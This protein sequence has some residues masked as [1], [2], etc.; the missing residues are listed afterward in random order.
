MF[1][2]QLPE[3]A[4]K[5]MAASIVDLSYGVTIQ[6]PV[7]PKLSNTGVLIHSCYVLAVHRCSSSSSFLCLIRWLLFMLLISILLSIIS[8]FTFS[9]PVC[10][11]FL[12]TVLTFLFR[13]F[14]L[15]FTLHSS[16]FSYLCFPF[17]FF[18]LSLLLS[19]SPFASVTFVCILTIFFSS[20]ISFSFLFFF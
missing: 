15:L 14:F 3:Q 8:L 16:S 1:P 13:P 18:I 17:I 7:D 5:E 4:V 11:V 6:E 2:S 9:F 19:V 20:Y 12:Y 10:L